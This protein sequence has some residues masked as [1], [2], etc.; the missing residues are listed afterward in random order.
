MSGKIL[1]E[2]G[3]QNAW[4]IEQ[5]ASEK[6][7]PLWIAAALIEKESGGRNVYGND[8]GGVF[9]TPGAPDLVVTREN[10]AEFERRVL[11]GETSNGVGPAQ[12]T[13]PG[14]IR[15]AMVEGIQLW[16]PLDNLRFGFQLLANYLNGHYND[17]QIR[18]AGTRYNGASAYG[19]DLVA[20][21]H[22]WRDRLERQDMSVPKNT[23][24]ARPTAVPALE[25]WL[26]DEGYDIYCG[27]SMAGTKCIRGKHGH[28]WKKDP[29]GR[30]TV[31]SAH[32]EDAMGGATGPH[33]GGAVDVGKDPS[34]GVPVSN[35]ERARL[36]DLGRILLAADWNVVWGV[37]LH[38]DHAHVDHRRH[39]PAMFV[40]QGP[41][42]PFWMH[43]ITF[44]QEA[45]S[46]I[47]NRSGDPFYTKRID[48]LRE[49]GTLA[50]I[51][52]YQMSRGLVTD[53]K[54]GPKTQEAL[55]KDLKMMEETPEPTPQP[56]PEPVPIP[57]VPTKRIAGPD[58]WATAVA[59]SKAAYPDGADV[60]Y[61]ATTETDDV[62]LAQA[63]PEGDGPVLLCSKG[64]KGLV[65]ATLNEV[66]RLKPK[67]IVAFGGDTGV[68]EAALKQAAR[69]AAE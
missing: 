42:Y 18:Y 16:N 33:V 14:F 25:K 3:L 22:I 50:A 17:N 56:E 4:L 45:L 5:A 21:A 57:A 6:R 34:A 59:I 24:L 44:V 46:K 20:R 9:S 38:F 36:D 26:R 39:N 61:L 48:G 37:E 12:I 64:R 65:L 66:R 30:V 29:D 51:K 15:E 60:V 10:Y 2:F 7:V 43:E 1:A 49:E 68:T 19:D 54:P 35:Y 58:R 62:S 67:R 32:Y 31:W 69:A 41:N 28:A 53:G 52:A 40:P 11:A 47:K 8:R 23:S 27:P 55:R 63:M 13:W